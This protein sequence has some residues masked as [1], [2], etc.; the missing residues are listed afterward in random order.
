MG[1][2]LMALPRVGPQTPRDEFFIQILL[3]WPPLSMVLRVAVTAAECIR[4][5][6]IGRLGQGGNS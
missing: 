6:E 4:G 2:V 3:P 5:E 1:P